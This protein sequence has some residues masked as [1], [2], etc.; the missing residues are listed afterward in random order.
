VTTLGI[1]PGNHP[2]RRAALAAHA[3]REALSAAGL[4][5]F[6]PECT[7]AVDGER[8]VVRLGEIDAAAAMA[9]AERLTPSRRRRRAA[10]GG[11]A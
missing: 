7:A 9:L 8:A 6:F 11:S 3:L 1:G 5:E 10:G 4:L 2:Q